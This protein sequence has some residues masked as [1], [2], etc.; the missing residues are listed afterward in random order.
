MAVGILTCF[1]LACTCFLWYVRRKA[2]AADI[3]EP[4]VEQN[5]YEINVLP[6]EPPTTTTDPGVWL[7]V[8]NPD[9]S[10]MLTKVD[11]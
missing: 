10:V 4:D 3:R 7:Y 11:T 6:A 8:H 2:L 9:H 1:S 5:T